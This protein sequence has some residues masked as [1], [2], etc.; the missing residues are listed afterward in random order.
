MQT[1]TRSKR[2]KP[3]RPTGKRCP[4]PQI[5]EGAE[6]CDKSGLPPA[7]VSFVCFGCGEVLPVDVAEKPVTSSHRWSY[8]GYRWN[9]QAEPE[10]GTNLRRVL[11]ILENSPCLCG[12]C[13]SKFDNET[14][15]SDA[16]CNA[17]Y[18]SG[19]IARLPSWNKPLR[20]FLADVDSGKRTLGITF[21]ITRQVRDRVTANGGEICRDDVTR[22]TL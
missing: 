20:R 16:G 4:L 22:G 9:A 14:R 19:K 2:V 13:A 15:R 18:G 8:G 1:T 6:K 12:K 5:P 17:F 10:V 11:T 21:T 7:T 3:S